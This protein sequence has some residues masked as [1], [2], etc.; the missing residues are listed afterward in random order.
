L[1]IQLPVNKGANDRRSIASVLLAFGGC[2]RK[3]E[4]PPKASRTKAKKKASNP[5]ASRSRQV[6]GRMLFLPEAAKEADGIAGANMPNSI[7][8][9]WPESSIKSSQANAGWAVWRIDS[10]NVRQPSF[11]ETPQRK[12]PDIFRL[13]IVTRAHFSPYFSL[14]KV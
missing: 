9:H 2:Q 10:R 7:S 4:Q 6:Q 11:L 13:G 1:L 3:G 14:R 12:R 5:S 8:R